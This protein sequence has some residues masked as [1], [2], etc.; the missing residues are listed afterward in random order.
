MGIET[1]DRNF[2]LGTIDGHDYAFHDATANPIVLTGLPFFVV[3]GELC[4]LPQAAIPKMNQGVQGLAW[5]TTGA[6]VRFRTNSPVI[7]V[8]AELRAVSDMNHMPRSGS[9]GFDI[10]LG[11]GTGKVFRKTAIPGP[12]Q[13]EYASNLFQVDTAEMR[14]FTINFP[15]YNGVRKLEIGIDPECLIEPPTPFA[16]EKPILF[17]GSSI[18]QGGCASRPGNAYTHIIA[19]RLDANLINYGFSGSARGTVEMAELLGT[20]AMSV[21]VYDYDHNA[22]SLD[23]L[24]K[25]HA[26]FF[27]TFRTAQPD[28]PVV[29]V[30]RCD[31]DGDMVA[32]RERRAVIRKTYDNARAAGDTRVLFVDGEILFGESERDACTVDGCHPNDLGF[33]RM[34]DGITPA[35]VEAVK[36]QRR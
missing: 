18:T 19:R 23:H 4:R 35:V 11:Q 27:R 20:I 33:M 26:P 9:S 7:A 14:E 17:Y 22:P 3:E 30:S 6:M 29:F 21:L 36:M 31:F 28:T 24:Q 32:S 8:R 1:I 25:T 34:A 10:Y 5:H 12:G 15:L 16:I 13:K 2:L